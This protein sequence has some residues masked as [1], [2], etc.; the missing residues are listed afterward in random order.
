M[1]VRLARN[2][3]CQKQGV[4]AN[5]CSRHTGAKMGGIVPFRIGAGFKLGRAGSE[6]KTEVAAPRVA[7]LALV[8]ALTVVAMSCQQSEPTAKPA[9]PAPSPAPSVVPAGYGVVIG[10][11]D[12][13]VGPPVPTP[14]AYAWGTVVVFRGSVIEQTLA[15]VQ[16]TVLPTELVASMAVAEGGE[17]RFALR[18]GPY[19]LVAQYEQWKS[20]WPW[21]SVSV[22]AGQTTRQDIPSSCF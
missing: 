2:G 1:R 20:G 16:Q 10:G 17:Y 6:L 13:C 14:P 7:R 8:V 22:V 11:I 5:G 19:V 9:A 12:P 4:D 15:G 3:F 18:P 21:M